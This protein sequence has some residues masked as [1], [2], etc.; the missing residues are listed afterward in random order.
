MAT[1]VCCLLEGEG[2]VWALSCGG[3]RASGAFESMSLIIFRIFKYGDSLLNRILALLESNSI[4][5]SLM[6][7][8][9][10]LNSSARIAGG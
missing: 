3:L 2:N 7:L 8:E 6:S 9:R 4:F 5:S 10:L 1:Y